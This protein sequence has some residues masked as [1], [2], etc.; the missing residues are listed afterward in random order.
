MCV[1]SEGELPFRA[2]TGRRATYLDMVDPSGG[3]AS[4]ES[5]AEGVELYSGE[6]VRFDALGLCNLRKL[7]GWVPP[8]NR[9]GLDDPLA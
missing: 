5:T 7:E 8:A 4:I 3:F 2:A 9:P 1:G 6:Y